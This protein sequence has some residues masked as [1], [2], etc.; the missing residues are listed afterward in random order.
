MFIRECFHSV[1]LLAP[2]KHSLLHALEASGYD[3]CNGAV[4]KS[5]INSALSIYVYC[6]HFVVLRPAQ[7]VGLVEK[8][9]VR[10][11][12]EGRVCEGYG[13]PWDLV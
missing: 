4:L 5:H 8:R 6:M 12:L 3:V 11:G 13:R 2:C 10:L 1:Y 9:R 7:R